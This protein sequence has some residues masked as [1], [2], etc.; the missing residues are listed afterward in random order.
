MTEKFLGDGETNGPPEKVARYSRGSRNANNLEHAANFLTP[1]SM[2]DVMNQLS[3]SER[4]LT[5]AGGV[6]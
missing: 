6:P 3:E 2:K 5:K 1:T 4:Y